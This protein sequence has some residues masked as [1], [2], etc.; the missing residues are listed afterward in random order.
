MLAIL[1]ELAFLISGRRPDP[2]PLAVAAVA[3]GVGVVAH[4][5]FPNLVE[6]FWIVNFKILFATAWADMPGFA[7]GTEFLPFDRWQFTY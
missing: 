3:V 5:N 2:R 6:F 1:V 4:P 7:Q